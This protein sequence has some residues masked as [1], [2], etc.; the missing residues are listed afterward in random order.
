[1]ARTIYQDA[2]IL[3][4][5]DPISALDKSVQ[6]DIFY[7]LLKKQMRYKTRVMV[8]N[9]IDFLPFFDRLVMMKDGQIIMQGTYD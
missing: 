6:R 1:L 4:L 7:K 3:L 8:T 9:S 5:D 2:S